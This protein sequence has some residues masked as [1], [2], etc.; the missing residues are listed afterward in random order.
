[1]RR[2]SKDLPTDPNWS[3]STPFIDP[4]R[5]AAQAPVLDPSRPPVDFIE[6][7][8]VHNQMLTLTIRRIRDLKKWQKTWLD[9]SEAELEDK[10]NKGY[11]PCAPFVKAPGDTVPLVGY[12]FKAVYNIQDKKSWFT[13]AHSPDPAATQH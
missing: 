13:F 1:M 6:P 4:D 10:A 8:S 12:S 5:R 11:H 9:C 7:Y 3:L 2:K